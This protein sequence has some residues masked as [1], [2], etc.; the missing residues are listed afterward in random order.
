M[1][2][3]FQHK[4]RGKNPATIAGLI[5]L[6]IIGIV[7]LGILF[8]FVI[9]WLWNALMPE[10]FGLGTI[11]YWQAVGLF[12]LVK[13]FVGGSGSHS[14][15]KSK[16]RNSSCK[17]KKNH[18]NDFSKWKHYDKFWQEEGSKAY[19]EYVDKLDGNNSEQTDSSASLDSP[20]EHIEE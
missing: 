9:M 10:I 19:D 1:T 3:Y 16:H 13:I 5:V 7:G 8:G 20:T 12:I 2:N 15:H 17:S 4:M 6:A 14:K 11:S 18:K